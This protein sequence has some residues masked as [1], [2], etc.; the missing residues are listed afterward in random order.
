[1]TKPVF[2][3]ITSDLVGKPWIHVF[4]KYFFVGGFA[5]ESRIG[6]LLHE[7]VGRRI[8]LAGQDHIV[9][10]GDETRRKRDMYP[11][12]AELRYLLS[13]ALLHDEDYDTYALGEPRLGGAMSPWFE[14]EGDLEEYCRQNIDALRQQAKP[15]E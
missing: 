7:D 8:Y 6:G 15:R 13:Y 9:M 10:E 3:T 14:S 4:G 11:T 12:I 1:M 2:I 5:G